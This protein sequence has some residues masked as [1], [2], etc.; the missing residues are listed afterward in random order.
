MFPSDMDT[1]TPPD[2][3]KVKIHTC[4]GVRVGVLEM[5]RPGCL[6]CPGVQHLAPRLDGCAVHQGANEVSGSLDRALPRVIREVVR[7][8]VPE[9]SRALDTALDSGSSA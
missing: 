2:T 4:A 8:V 7:G 5:W 6:G 3:S 1:R 9:F